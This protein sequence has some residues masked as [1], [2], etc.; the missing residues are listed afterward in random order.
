VTE[1][2]GLSCKVVSYRGLGFPHASESLPYCFNLQPV[3]WKGIP[4]DCGMRCTRRVPQS[5]APA[6]AHPGSQEEWKGSEAPLCPAFL[7]GRL[8]S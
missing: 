4:S 3:S 6:W 8:K 7:F 5:P 2:A 1:L